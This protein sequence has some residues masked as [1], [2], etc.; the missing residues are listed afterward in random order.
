MAFVLDNI[1]KHIIEQHIL[2]VSEPCSTCILLLC[3]DSNNQWRDLRDC[4]LN[5]DRM[6]R[7]IVIL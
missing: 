4:E 7:Y 2:I 6:G 1:L 3:H 5:I